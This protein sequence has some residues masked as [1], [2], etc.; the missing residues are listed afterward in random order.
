MSES[1]N[2]VDRRTDYMKNPRNLLLVVVY[3]A[4]K[5]LVMKMCTV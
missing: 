5:H 1:V 4:K 3:I 2:L